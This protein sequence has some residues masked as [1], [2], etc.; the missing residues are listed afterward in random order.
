MHLLY[1]AVP[2]DTSVF[3]RVIVTHEMAFARAICNRVFYM[4]EGGIYEDG[5]PEEIFDHPKRENTCRF[6]RRLKVLELNIESRDYDFLG[7]STLIRQYCEKNQIAPKVATRTRL[8]FEETMQLLIPRLE[9]PRVQA[10]VEYSE[11]TEAAEWTIR[12]GGPHF[13]LRQEGENLALT[14]LKGMTG[15][16]DYAFDENAELPNRLTLR[17]RQV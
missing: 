15:E 16:T 7:M 10:V 1:H 13:D 8:D 6:V 12:Y 5:T 2:L 14:V 11:A 3:F 17:I 9:N 4:D